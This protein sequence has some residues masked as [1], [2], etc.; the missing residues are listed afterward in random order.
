MPEDDEDDDDGDGYT[1]VQASAVGV[2]FLEVLGKLATIGLDVGTVFWR[3]A[4]LYLLFALG[5][6]DELV[7]LVLAL[8]SVDVNATEAAGVTRG[9]EGHES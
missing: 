3:L 9:E 4:T 6:L 2:G 5:F 1:G 7:E 8:G